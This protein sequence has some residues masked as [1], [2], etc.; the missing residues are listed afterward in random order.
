APD[1]DVGTAP[2]AGGAY[3]FTRTGAGWTEQARLTPPDLPADA[4]FGRAVA[5]SSDYILVGAP[6]RNEGAVS[7]AGAAYLF[8]RSGPGWNLVARL[9][10]GDATAFAGFGSAV[11]LGPGVAVVGAPGANAV[12]VFAPSGGTWTQVQRLTASDADT[13]WGLDDF[14]ESVALD[15]KRLVVG[16]PGARLAYVFTFD[17]TAWKETDKLTAKVETQALG[18]SVALAGNAVFVADPEFAPSI[19]EPL[20]G[21]VF[22]YAL[23]TSPVATE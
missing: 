15:G 9:T 7:A 19:W 6:Y 13:R 23:P 14:G 20:T 11:A 3:V 22:E 10:A 17:G 21:A 2:N 5:V 8:A 16:A 12:Y 18:R 1:K 4:A